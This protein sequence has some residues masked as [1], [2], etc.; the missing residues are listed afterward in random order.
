[1]I[2]FL[3]SGLWHGA[4]WTFI[5]WGGLNGFY[6]MIELFIKDNKLLKSLKYN[7]GFKTLLSHIITIILIYMVQ[8]DILK[9]TFWLFQ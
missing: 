9:S 7:K 5:I 3:L 8:P 2:T 4:N 6:L 1:M